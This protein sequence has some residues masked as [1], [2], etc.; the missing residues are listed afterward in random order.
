MK[1]HRYPK[2]DGKCF[3]C[4]EDTRLPIHQECGDK[5]KEKRRKYKTGEY[6]KEFIDYMA[7]K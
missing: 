1:L 3:V 7:D 5:V 4:G 6:K 2:A